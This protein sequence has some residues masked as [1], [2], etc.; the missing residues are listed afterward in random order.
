ME[1]SVAFIQPKVVVNGFPKGGTNLVASVLDLLGMQQVP[2]AIASSLL[3]GRYTIVRKALWGCGSGHPVIVGIDFP[4]AVKESR[5]IQMVKRLLPG[6]YIAAHSG[7]SDHLYSIFIHGGLK[8]IQVI[9]DPRDIVASHAVYCAT[10]KNHPLYSYYASISAKQR[11][12]FSI[13]GGHT[14]QGYFL[15]SIGERARSVDGWI[16]KPN[17]FT[18]RFEDL[19]G[20]KGGGS[21]TIQ[22]ETIKTLIDFLGIDANENVV[23]TI[24]QTVWGREGRTFRKGVIGNWRSV[25]S[26]DLIK[27]FNASARDITQ[28]WGYDVAN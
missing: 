20:E 8:I 7:Y 16:G 6:N 17:V 27:L 9:R 2:G 26:A 13:Q 5:V 10:Q 24:C 19:V 1:Y 23:T 4:V 11:L 12:A 21:D 22:Y 3:F 15:E 28:K 18:V 25:F 14:P